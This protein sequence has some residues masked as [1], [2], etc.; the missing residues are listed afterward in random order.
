[1]SLL[2]VTGASL[3]IQRPLVEEFVLHDSEF[4]FCQWVRGSS[5]SQGRRLD[6]FVVFLSSALRLSILV[7]LR[8]RTVYIGPLPENLE[9]RVRIM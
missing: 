3:S 8:P 5:Q 4:D 6:L 7:A 2:K 1:M 9:R